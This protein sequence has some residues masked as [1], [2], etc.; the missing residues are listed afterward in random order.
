MF[1]LYSVPLQ[2]LLLLLM[3]VTQNEMD[4]MML[5]ITSYDGRWA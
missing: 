2:L 4:E 3:L 5:L 1:G